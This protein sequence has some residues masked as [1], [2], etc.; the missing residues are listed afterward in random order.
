MESNKIHKFPKEMR[1]KIKQYVY[2]LYGISRL[3]KPNKIPK[4]IGRG[5][6]RSE[7]HATKTE[8][9]IETHEVSAAREKLK[10]I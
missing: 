2:L 7:I 4:T 3:Q 10:Q 9:T 5:Q 1:D 8:L 6:N